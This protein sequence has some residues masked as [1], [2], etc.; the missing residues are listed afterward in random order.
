MAFQGDT[1]MTVVS[2]HAP[3]GVTWGIDKPQQ[4]IA[5]ARRLALCRGPV[6]VGADANTPEVDA[7]DFAATRTH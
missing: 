1:E 7:P 5:L 3:P 2:Y 6:L 4:A